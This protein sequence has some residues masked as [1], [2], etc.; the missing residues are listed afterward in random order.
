[1]PTNP[2]ITKLIFFLTLHRFTLF[3]FAYL[4]VLFIQATATHGPVVERARAWCQMVGVPYYRFSSPMSSDVGLDETDDRILVKML[5]ETRVYVLQN[6]KEFTELGKKLTSW[7]DLTQQWDWF[8]FLG[9]CNCACNLACKQFLQS[10]NSR[11]AFHLNLYLKLLTDLTYLTQRT[12]YLNNNE[13][14]Y[15]LIF[16]T[17]C[18]F[19]FP[20]TVYKFYSVKYSKSRVVKVPFSFSPENQI[21]LYSSIRNFCLTCYN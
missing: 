13:N 12:R 7:S 10:V 20:N 17:F 4:F 9:C 2:L 16:I 6:F 8:R 5:W 1:M 18:Y 3:S 19:S 14:I 21:V 11:L 15:F